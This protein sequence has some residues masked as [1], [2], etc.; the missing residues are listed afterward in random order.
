[1]ER[2]RA[3]WCDVANPFNP[4]SVSRVSLA[5]ADVPAIVFWTKNAAP[6]L[7][8]LDELDRRGF[9][10]YFLFTLNA[11]PEILEPAV[12]PL[13]R[14]L[15]TFRELSR[16]LGAERVVWRYDPIILSDRLDV[17]FHLAQVEMLAN[18]LHGATRRLIVS[19]VDFYRKTERQ[20]QRIAAETGDRFCRNPVEHPE[21]GRLAHGLI[22]IAG[23]HGLDP[24]TCAEDERLRALGLKPGKCIDDEL[25][26]RALGVEV[27]DRK[28]K[29]Q[30]LACLCVG[31][32]DIGTPDTC[33]HACAYC[34]AAAS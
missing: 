26:Q 30:R 4:K 29:G 5:P 13:P 7:Q 23:Q 25:I 24:Q 31:S 32:R 11:Y 19:F 3:G 12:P 28:D 22:R 16:R 15:A 17:S 27:P 33:R 8:H 1:M 20:L 6:F 9:R 18:A 2:I 14:R 10:Y 21:I 34:Y